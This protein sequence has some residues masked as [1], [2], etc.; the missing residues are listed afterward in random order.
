[1][2][3]M[4]VLF[5]EQYLLLLLF[6]VSSVGWGKLF[7]TNLLKS[8]EITNTSRLVLQTTTGI[9]IVTLLFIIAGE[10]KNLKMYPLT[11]IFFGGITLFLIQLRV[12]SRNHIFQFRAAPLADFNRGAS[13]LLIV[14]AASYL[15]KP[16]VRALQVPDSWDELMY[17]LPMA[18][19]WAES[20]SLI[21][22]D[23]L[24]YPLFP[25]NMELL[26]AGALIF[27]N[28]V[29]PHLIHT[30]TGLLAI[31]LTYS[32]S[33]I[34]LPTALS[35]LAAFWLYISVKSAMGTADIDVGLTLYIFCAFVSLGYRFKDG[36]RGFCFLAAFFMGL[37]LGTK[38][39]AMFYLP[40][41][42]T[43]FFLAERNWKVI[44]TAVCITLATG[45]YWYIRSYVVSGD[46][47]HPIGGP[48]F[49]YWQW[50]ASDLDNQFGNLQTVIGLPPWY[51]MLSAGSLIFWR[52]TPAILR[53][54]IIA[55]CLNVVVWMAI[56]GYD[57]YLM[58]AYPL[59]SILSVYFIHRVIERT[60]G[61]T[62]MA[63]SWNRIEHT[64]R[65][66]ITIVILL[67]IVG[68]SWN[69][70]INKAELVFPDPIDRASY[71]KNEFPGYELLAQLETPISGKIYQL[72]FEG[73]IYYLGPQVMGDHF[74]VA[75]YKDVIKLLNKPS[76]LSSHLRSLGADY[77][78]VD[79]LLY[80]KITNKM[81]EAPKYIKHF[82]LVSGTPRAA[83]Y[84]IRDPLIP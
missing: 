36:R 5:F 62:V 21:V 81:S 25:F 1:M 76:K 37:A 32:I 19:A 53:G 39:Q 6:F 16:L 78:L 14:A 68:S 84:R 77:F 22:A 55:C 30:L 58:P 8:N 43:C 3:S 9:G 67:V 28:D 13:I 26:Y 20:G 70:T 54:C 11:A 47:I 46:P 66:T 35:L 73:E 17:H 27:G 75:R 63:R 71:L 65:V 23:W 12:V 31:A 50:N 29:T 51:L 79:V 49:G 57:R 52:S 34:F 45:G 82:D 15:L 59:L 72:R 60:D 2:N 56:S 80:P 41:F 38:Y 33:K 44:G 48:V 40:A 7:T 18:Q 24:R 61:Y 64:R 4:V 74:G 83:L 10:T 42:A 69:S